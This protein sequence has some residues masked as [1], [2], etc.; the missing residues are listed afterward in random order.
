MGLLP[1]LEAHVP[2]VVPSDDDTDAADLAAQ[3][4]VAHRFL[5]EARARERSLR[6]VAE[7]Q[8]KATT[9]DKQD[10]QAS[11]SWLRVA[12]TACPPR[13]RASAVF[14]GALRVGRAITHECFAILA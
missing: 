6:V 2:A 13:R 10:L 4:A 5:V 9:L 3:Q 8:L 11:L 14:I 12:N 1:G 7:N